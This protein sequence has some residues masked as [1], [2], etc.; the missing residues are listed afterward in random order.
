ME[1][2]GKPHLEESWNFTS[3]IW[4]GKWQMAGWWRGGVSKG[5]GDALWNTRPGVDI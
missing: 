2:A 5:A 4:G 1:M 3:R